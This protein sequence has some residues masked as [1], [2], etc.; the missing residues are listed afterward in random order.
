MVYMQQEAQLS[1]WDALVGANR[2]MSNSMKPMQR[3]QN[4]PAR[5]LARQGKSTIRPY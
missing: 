2:A 1:Q 5:E 4:A 3:T